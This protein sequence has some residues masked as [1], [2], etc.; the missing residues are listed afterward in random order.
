MKKT[1]RVL[2][3]F[4][5]LVLVLALIIPLVIPLPAPSNLT[6]IDQIKDPDSQFIQINGLNVHYKQAGSGGTAI[7]LLH[8]FGASTFSWRDVIQSLSALGTTLAYD[9]PAFGL[10]DRPMPGEWSGRSPYGLDAQ[11]DQLIGLMDAKGIKRA[12]LVGN[13]AGGAV[14]VAAA[15]Q[16]PQRVQALVLVDAA[17]YSGGG[18]P[19]WTKPLLAT[20]QGRWYGPLLARQIQESGMTLLRTAWHD[21]TKTSPAVIDGYR[22]PLQ[23]PNWDRALWELTLAQAP[24]NLAGRLSEL[25]MPTLVITGD[26]DR[27]VPTEQ[28]LRLAREIPGAT[29]ALLQFCGH[30]PQEECPEKFLPAVVAFIKN[31]K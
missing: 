9:R 4:V 2:A 1:L 13:S 12:V 3:I 18:L 26:D 22:K 25:K 5:L 7:L 16:Y 28:S 30:V 14:S 10:T 24:A 20:P 15:L 19:Q 17:I 6:S 8:G 23:V 29:L 11:V 27:V 31:L 21:P